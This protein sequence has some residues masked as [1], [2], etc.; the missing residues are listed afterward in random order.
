MRVF[1]Y[2][3]MGNDVSSYRQSIGLFYTKA[4]SALSKK[5]RVLFRLG[6]PYL[7]VKI[8]TLFSKYIQLLARHCYSPFQQNIYFTLILLLLLLLDNDIHQNPGPHE[9]EL[10]IFHLNARSVRNKIEYIENIASDSSII[11][12][13][14]SHL[15]GAV[16]DENLY[17]EGFSEVLFRK[18][19][20]S[21]GEGSSYIRRRVSMQRRGKT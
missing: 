14:E 5:Y 4:Y 20:N 11:A 10:S 1:L 9:F 8:W 16:P 2:L 19:R 12:I 17:I 18:D 6:S 7:M 3:I 15:D 21:F 13:T